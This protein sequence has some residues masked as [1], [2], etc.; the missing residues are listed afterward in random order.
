VQ[1]APVV[2]VP[3]PVV[4]AGRPARELALEAPAAPVARLVPV[5]V[6]AVPVVPAVVGAR[7]EGSAL[8][9]AVGPVPATAAPAVPVAA[10]VAPAVPAVVLV[11][12]LAVVPVE[13]PAA[14]E[15]LVRAG[16]PRSA[17]VAD[18]APSRSW[19]RRRPPATPART[20]PSPRAK[21]SSSGGR[22]LRSWVP[23]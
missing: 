2:R 7:V 8:I 15:G 23:S 16:V 13:V 5:E 14:G 22:A 18:V 4:R 20:R 3:V 1:V 10:P 12:G 21:L 19:S 11:A 17:A 6:Q 9:A